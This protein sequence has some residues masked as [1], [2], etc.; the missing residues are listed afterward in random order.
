MEIAQSSFSNKTS[1]RFESDGFAYMQKDRSGIRNSYI[2]YGDVLLNQRFELEE[3]SEYLRNIGLLWFV[4]GA[5]LTIMNGAIS[6]WLYV[7]AVCLV[8]YH[9]VSTKYSVIP[10]VQGNILIIRDKTHDQVLGILSKKLNEYVLSEFG[11]IN[12]DRTFEEERKKYKVMLSNGV[13][14]EAQFNEFLE[15]M[16]ANKTKFKAG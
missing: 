1:F 5:V 12:F 14:G 9:F 6:F 11:E 7:G 16:E 15:K 2:K 3:K 10:S 8:V 4:L 13:I